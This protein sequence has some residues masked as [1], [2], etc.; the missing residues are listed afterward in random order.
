[1]SDAERVN[2]IVSRETG[3]RWMRWRNDSDLPCPPWGWFIITGSFLDGMEVIW[4]GI[5]NDGPSTVNDNDDTGVSFKSGFNSEQA[6]DP[7]ETGRFTVDLPTWCLIQPATSDVADP[8][9]NEIGLMGFYTYQSGCDPW[10]LR[11]KIVGAVPS[12]Q[13]DLW[14]GYR[15]FAIRDISEFTA[16]WRAKLGAGTFATGEFRIGLIG[17]LVTELTTGVAEGG[18]TIEI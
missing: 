13:Y 14:D 1:V 15:V 8:I 9:E 5:V 2:Q 6:V 18:E 17:G 3:Q 16:I 11:R 12:A 4:T 10:A 7:N